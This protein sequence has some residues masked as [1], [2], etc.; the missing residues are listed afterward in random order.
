[1]GDPAQC[2]CT[3]Q[4]GG[5]KAKGQTLGD[6]YPCV[7]FRDVVELEQLAWAI[8]DGVFIPSRVR[9]M[10]GYQDWDCIVAHSLIPLIY[11]EETMWN[12]CGPTTIAGAN[13]QRATEPTK[14]L[15]LMHYK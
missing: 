14:E 11:Q 13:V 15:G 4:C 7:D 6:A 10:S 1:M 8:Y 5:K 2:C 3:E 9:E 12:L